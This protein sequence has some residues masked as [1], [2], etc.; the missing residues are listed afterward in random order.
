MENILNIAERQLLAS[1]VGE[2]FLF[3]AGKDL[4]S[5]LVSDEIVI[6]TQDKVLKLQGALVED[7]FAGFVDDYGKLKVALATQE[8]KLFFS[9]GSDTFM[10]RYAAEINEVFLVRETLTKKSG[11]NTLWKYVSDVGIVFALD[12]GFLCCTL[13]SH[14]NELFVV[15]HKN[16]FHLEELERTTSSF[17]D[18]LFATYETTR[19]VLDLAG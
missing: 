11:T 2:K 7:D 9:E 6:N 17:T 5:E 14:G 8:E 12:K 15:E 4:G 3:I 1:L 13:L 10:H 16:Q 19:E 18:D